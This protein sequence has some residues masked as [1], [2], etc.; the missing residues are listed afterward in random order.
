[1]NKDWRQRMDEEQKKIF[2]DSGRQAA[3]LYNGAFE[4][5]KNSKQAEKIV[6]LFFSATMF[7]KD[8]TV[9]MLFNMFGGKE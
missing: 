6:F 3:C 8:E 1:M 2:I 4:V 7:G 5:L 9:S